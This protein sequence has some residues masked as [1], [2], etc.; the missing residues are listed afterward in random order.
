MITNL[1]KDS[2]CE[3]WVNRPSLLLPCGCLSCLAYGSK[4]V[5]G[6]SDDEGDINTGVDSEV[7]NLLDD[8]RGAPDINDAL[9][10]SHLKVVVGVGTVTARGTARCHGQ[11]LG[12]DTLGAGNFVALLLSTGDNLSAGMLKGLDI[13]ATEGH[14]DLVDVFVD[15]FNLLVFV[16]HLN[17]SQVLRI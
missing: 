1:C 13:A 12:G 3:K 15:L 10:D 4:S 8:G 16:C 11:D 17:R 5:V 6:E 7:G 14:S 2:S 9:V